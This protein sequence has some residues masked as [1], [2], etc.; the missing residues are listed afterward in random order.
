MMA[1]VLQVLGALLVIAG[2]AW[3]SPALGLVVAG[4]F[5]ISAGVVAE[6]DA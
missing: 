6:V 3:V 1:D 2:L 4:L 5:L